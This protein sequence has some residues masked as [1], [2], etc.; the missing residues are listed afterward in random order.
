MRMIGGESPTVS[1][2]YRIPGVDW[3]L[4][5]QEQFS[6]TTTLRH[7]DL[8]GLPQDNTRSLLDVRQRARE[9]TPPARKGR[10]QADNKP[11]NKH[12]KMY[13]QFAK[14]PGQTPGENSRDYPRST[15]VDGDDRRYGKLKAPVGAACLPLM[16]PWT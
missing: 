10:F 11:N 4:A 5:E 15:K 14:P 3:L 7:A 12:H 2:L 9:L 13:R 8:N 16:I 6:S 1:R